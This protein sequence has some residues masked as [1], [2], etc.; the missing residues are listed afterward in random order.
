VTELGRLNI[1]KLSDIIHIVLARPGNS[2]RVS[3]VVEFQPSIHRVIL[4][5]RGLS[6]S[7]G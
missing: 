7:C 1:V 5:S 3:L 4:H 6:L 2:D